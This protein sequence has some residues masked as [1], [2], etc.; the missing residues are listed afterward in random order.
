MYISFRNILNNVYNDRNLNH[1]ELRKK[2]TFKM[3]W[4]SFLLCS[5]LVQLC[6][7]GEGER[8]DDGPVFGGKGSKWSC[9]VATW[10]LRLQNCH[11]QEEEV[12]HTLK[13]RESQSIHVV[14]FPQVSGWSDVNGLGGLRAEDSAVFQPGLYSAG[15]V[16]SNLAA[17]IVFPPSCQLMKWIVGRWVSVQIMKNMIR[18][19]FLLLFPS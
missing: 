1:K 10:A 17:N 11:K 9:R 6:L 8:E 7:C 5:E 12:M 19:F 14:H 3:V 2:N 18:F 15:W 16:S 4:L 13:E